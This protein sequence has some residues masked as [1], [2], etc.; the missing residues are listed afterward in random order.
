MSTIQN[1]YFSERRWHYIFNDVQYVQFELLFQAENSMPEVNLW[2][3]SADGNAFCC[4]GFSFLVG[5]FWKNI[6]AT[7]TVRG[8]KDCI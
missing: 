3:S 1:E 8:V 6:C 5:A 2:S 4:T 7:I